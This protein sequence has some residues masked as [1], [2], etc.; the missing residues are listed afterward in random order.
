[1]SQTTTKKNNRFGLKSR[2]TIFISLLLVAASSI[3]FYRAQAV[4]VDANGNADTIQSRDDKIIGSEDNNNISIEAATAGDLDPIFLGGGKVS[5]NLWSGNNDYGY[6]SARQPDGKIV[7]AGQTAGSVPCIVRYNT[8]GSLDQTFG[9]TVYAGTNTPKGLACSFT[10]SGNTFYSDVLIQS[11]GKIVAIGAGNTG[12]TDRHTIVTRFNSDGSADTT[13]SGDGVLI[14]SQNG[15]D[16]Y[17]ESGVIQPDG[18]I[19]LVGKVNDVTAAVLRINTDGSLDTT[20]NGNG[21]FNFNCAGYSRCF[22]SSVALDSAGRIVVGGYGLGSNNDYIF[23]RINPSGGL[24]STFVGGGG[25]IPAGTGII[26]V[27]ITASH[28]YCNGIL[29]QPDGKI[30]G[31]GYSDASNADFSAVRLNTNG[32]LDTSF[33]TDGRI[34]TNFGLN[35]RGFGVA[36]QADGKIVIAGES[37]LSGSRYDFALARYNIN[38]SL[39]TSFDGDG[40]LTTQFNLNNSIARDVLIEPDGKIIAA[41]YSNWASV[42]ISAA[43]YNPNGSLDTSW[44]VGKQQVN[45]NPSDNLRDDLASGVAQQADG[46]LVTVGR[47]SIS[48]LNRFALT[49]HNTDGTLDTGFG[50]AGK[51]TSPSLVFSDYG[52][53]VAIDPATQKIIVGGYAWNGAGDYDFLLARY[54]TNGS[55]DTTFGTSGFKRRHNSSEDYIHAI[56]LMSDG[57]IVAVGRTGNIDIA[58]LRFDVATNDWDSA[59][60][61]SG[62]RVIH[63]AGLDYGTSVVIDANGKILIGG[64]STPSSRDFTLLRLNPANGSFDT[65]FNTTG[66]VTTSI[67]GSNTDEIE[68]IAIQ[69]DGKIV[70][71][72]FGNTGAGNGDDFIVARYNTNG[73]LDTSFDFDGIQVTPFTSSSDVGNGVAIQADGKILASGY[74]FGGASYDYAFAR[75]NTDGSLD[76]TF[77]NGGRRTY[78]FSGYNDYGVGNLIIQPDGKA[79]TVAESHNGINWDFGIVRILTNSQADCSYSL[80]QTSQNVVQAGAS[81]SVNVTTTSECTWTAVSNVSWLQF[82]GSTNGTGNGTINY[83]V[84]A[85]PNAVSRTGQITIGGQTLTVT[86]YGSNVAVSIPTGMTG[87]NG[88]VLTVPLNVS[89][90]TGQGILSY[91]FTL[92]YDQTVLT[93]Q[94]TPYGTTGTLSSGFTITV[95]PNTP[96]TLVVSGFGTSPLSGS[97]TLLNLKFNVV[98][99]YPNCSN[100]NFTAFTFNAGT[101]PNQTTNGQFCVINGNISGTITYVN[102]S[103]TQPA[104]QNV[105]VSAVGSTTI[106]TTTNASGYY[107]LTGF[108]SGAYTVTPT[109]TGDVNGITAFDAALVAQHVVGLITLTSTQQTAGDTSNNGSLNSFDAALIAQYAASI[110]NPLSIA[111]TWKFSPSSRNY[112]SVIMDTPN[113]DYSAILVGEVSGN[114]T[115]PPPFAGLP[116]QSVNTENL[117]GVTL[118]TMA[119]SPNMNFS[120]PITVQDT[121]GKGI[122]AYEFDLTY[123]PGV[124]QLQASPVDTSGTLSNDM[125]VT[126]NASTEGLA[127][128]AVFGVAPRNGAGVLLRLKFTSVGSIGSVSPLTW[129]RFMFN[130]NNPQNV[131]TNGQVRIASPTASTADICGRV[132]DQFGEGLSDVGVRLVD[133]QSGEVFRRGTNKKGSYCFRSVSIGEDYIIEPSK[134]GYSFA[135]LS[136]LLSLNGSQDDVD[137]VAIPTESLQEES[138]ENNKENKNYFFHDSLQEFFGNITG[139][140]GKIIVWRGDKLIVE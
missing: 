39:D 123:D 54:N 68:A 92:T 36:I 44:G 28:D 140:K 70:V 40:R 135:P 138:K 53:S 72:G 86:Q 103:P 77:G 62:L 63:I 133:V 31:A 25:T 91:D 5:L 60:G 12:G 76:T 108:S 106:N 114:W 97:G 89:D 13:F 11:D 134:K 21:A 33:D 127:K 118:P 24:D 132:T 4:S 41:G 61:T 14:Y 137:F 121:T 55:L 111:G 43:R 30:V 10:W 101:P 105:A 104:V 84:D 116:L 93:P 42:D 17:S 56:A 81:H 139:Q 102:G 73:S 112:A 22:A 107:E 79:V 32:S 37:D 80:S 85:N 7:I 64:S 113:Q 3:A 90:T 38:G 19:V 34:Q 126:V 18:K 129:T 95:N 29:I 82:T 78:D 20:F 75:Y 66:I 27:Q 125:I 109:K 120:V 131:A 65:T 6:A 26:A 99:A 35:E 74:A 115:P 58:V 130:E 8:D 110:S 117:I 57:D 15:G 87:Q 69:P 1:M 128:V 23:A 45:F 59:F 49:R 100:L 83:S 124:I 48:S 136:R 46:K 52:E 119:V 96:G 47:S 67:N 88:A 50:S 16:D 122:I 94:V 2:V 71:S 98:G 51:A 9:N